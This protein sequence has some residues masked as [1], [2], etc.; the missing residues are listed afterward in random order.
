MG[1]MS[2]AA[3]EQTVASGSMKKKEKRKMTSGWVNAYLKEMK[4]NATC[5]LT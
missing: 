5:I 1:Q 4:W 2:E 3:C